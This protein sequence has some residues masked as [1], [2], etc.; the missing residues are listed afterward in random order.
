MQQPWPTPR[1]RPDAFV[2]GPEEAV[3]Q[4]ERLLREG[5][6]RTLCVHGDNPEAVA[7]VRALRQALAQKGIAVRK[8][9]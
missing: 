9:A 4:T 7:F 5:K 8:L 6:V 3:H 2:E 1:G